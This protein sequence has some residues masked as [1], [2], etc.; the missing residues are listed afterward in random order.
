MDNKEL[1]LIV[2]CK[3]YDLEIGNKV[4]IKHYHLYII[5]SEFD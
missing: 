1:K 2:P 3:F 5:N 4:Q